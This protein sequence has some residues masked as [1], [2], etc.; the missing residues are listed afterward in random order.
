MKAEIHNLVGEERVP[1]LDIPAIGRAIWRRRRRILVA[2]F[3]ILVP[4]V[5]T[6]VLLPPSYKSSAAILIESQRVPTELVATTITGLAEERVQVIRRQVLTRENIL[7]LVSKFRLYRS[8]S[9]S[10]SELVSRFLDNTGINLISLDQSSRLS[11]RNQ[12]TVIAFEL[13]FLNRNPETAQQV[14]ND[15]VTLFLDENA[16]NRTEIASEATEFLSGESTKLRETI[17]TLEQELTSYK[18]ENRDSLPSVYENNVLL[19][20]RSLEESASI[21]LELAGIV[22]ELELLEVRRSQSRLFVGENGLRLVDLQRAYSEFLI[23]NSELHPTA[24]KLRRQIEDLNTR[25]SDQDSEGAEQSSNTYNPELAVIEVQI[26]TASSRLE[27]LKSRGDSLREMVSTVQQRIADT[28]NTE[29]KLATLEREVE[30]YRANYAKLRDKELGARMA[31]SLESD[32]KGERLTVL[33][34]PVVP[35]EPTEPNRPKLLVVGIFFAGALGGLVFLASEWVDPGI[36]GL[37]T[38]TKELGFAPLAALP[39]IENG[40]DR[41]AQRSWLIFW[42]LGVSAIGIA[43]V[44]TVHFFVAS[45]DI[46]WFALLR[47]LGF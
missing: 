9:L 23:E 4:T 31:Q 33:E 22:A 37:S 35:T 30:T 2:F 11:R 38:F 21:D 45:L 39:Y 19:L 28:P 20:D 32:R 3:A 36:R 18:A 5:V 27:L 43:S 47:R 34:P 24:A 13:Y 29:R 10:Q 8:E 46:V 26:R 25:Q 14:A 40:Q 12:N 6:V 17:A 1:E 16:R 44:L 7:N 15:L 41:T 42:L